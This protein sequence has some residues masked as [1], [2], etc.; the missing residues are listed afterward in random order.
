MARGVVVLIPAW[1]PREDLYSFV[2]ELLSVGFAA[3]VAVDDGSDSSCRGVFD[4]LAAQG[5]MCFD[6]R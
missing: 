6:M 5:C 1:N 3:V 2:A 4:S